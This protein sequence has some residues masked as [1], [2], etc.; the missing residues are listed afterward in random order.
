MTEEMDEKN[1]SSSPRLCI[2]SNRAIMAVPNK[3]HTVILNL[4]GTTVSVS[5]YSGGEDKKLRGVQ[6]REG[7]QLLR[8]VG[9]GEGQWRYPVKGTYLC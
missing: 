3:C 5:V 1:S 9:E 7:P 4:V 6:E 2:L 8:K